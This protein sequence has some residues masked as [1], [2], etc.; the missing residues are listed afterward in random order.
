MLVKCKLF[1]PEMQIKEMI[2]GTSSAKGIV[3]QKTESMLAKSI[4]NLSSGIYLKTVLATVSKLVKRNLPKQ[5][6]L[7]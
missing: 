2:S 1:I 5:K 6:D 3:L 4:V 7:K